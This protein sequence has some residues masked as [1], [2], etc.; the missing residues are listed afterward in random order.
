MEFSPANLLDVLKTFPLVQRLCVAYSG[1]LD[2][3]VLLQVLHGLRGHLAA[4]LV[5]VHVDHGLHGDAKAWAERCRQA[6]ERLGVPFTVL[7]VD[8]KAEP[9][10]SPE[11]AAR[12]VRYQAFADWLKEGD[13]LLTAHHE[14]DQAETVLLQMLRGSGPP[15]LAAMPLLRS[16]GRAYHG[17]PLL[18][19]CRAQLR[20]YAKDH[21]LDW[22][23]DPSNQQCHLDRNRLRHE[24][25]PKLRERWPG[26][27]TTLARVAD[28]QAEAAT[29]LDELAQLDLAGMEGSVA[30]T[31]SVAGLTG[32]D[33][34]RC[35]NLL[36][37]WFRLRELPVPSRAVLKRIEEDLLRAR[38]DGMPRVAWLG[39]EVRR[40]RDLLYAFKPLPHHDPTQCVTWEP[41]EP[42]QLPSAGGV[43]Y[44]EAVV[45]EGLKSQYCDRPLAIRFRHGGERCRPVGRQHHHRLKHLF[46]ERGVPPWERDRTPLI[47]VGDQLAAIAGLW[48]CESF[49]AGPEEVGLCIRWQRGESPRS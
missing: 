35:R 4:P 43:L 48:V 46:Q 16:L 24:I 10:Q 15:G 39:S 26:I 41:G 5:A 1:G 20:A 22:I 34:R 45:G 9:G 17:R 47:Y 30:N 11:A 36:R 44:G 2:S 7:T 25:I 31:L 8:G 33:P 21:G 28:N 19:F 23:E 6:C 40:Y 32:L 27:G 14:D 42:L 37:Y 38:W 13:C 12:Q 18:Y 3:E 49:Q 29:L